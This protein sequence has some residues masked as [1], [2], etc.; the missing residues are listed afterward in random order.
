MEILLLIGILF[1]LFLAWL[2][3][4]LVATLLRRFFRSL[5]GLSLKEDA[6]GQAR[7]QDFLF[8]KP[9][10]RYERRERKGRLNL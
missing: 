2:A 6:R 9:L 4:A 8:G 7:A 10:T 1:V 5:L 3:Y